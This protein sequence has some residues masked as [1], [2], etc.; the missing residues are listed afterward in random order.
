MRNTQ[1]RKGFTLIELLVVI[2]II[3]ILAAIL[4]PVFAK[5]REKA[6]QT[7]CASNE[8]QL[9]LGFIQYVQ[10]YDEKWPIGIGTSA[11]ATS[12]SWPDEIFPYVKSVGVFKCPDDSTQNTTT[13]TYALS[14][15]MNYN[16]TADSQTA[17]GNSQASLSSPT[18][19]VLAFDY[20]E[21][22]VGNFTTMPPSGMTS[23]VG[24][25]VGGNSAQLVYGTCTLGFG[26]GSPAIH[27]PEIMF[28]ACDGHVKLLRPEKVSCGNDA[29]SQST[30]PVITGTTESSAAGTSSNAMSGN[31]FTLT[32]SE[33]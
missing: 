19:T 2:A 21:G 24:A 3:A 17:G 23:G 12:I 9:G 31:T 5:A 15:A 20:D 4:F 13:P 22:T 7:S 1:Y 8:K 26:C 27:D 18:S 6:R 30:A 11:N 33:I 25:F 10:D 14:Y 32:F 16:L 29:A 28:L